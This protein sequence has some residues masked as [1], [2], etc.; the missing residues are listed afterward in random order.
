[1]SRRSVGGAPEPRLAELTDRELALLGLT[2]P[3]WNEIPE[4]RYLDTGRFLVDPSHT[5]RTFGLAATPGDEM[6]GDL[7]R[8]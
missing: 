5:E 3:F 7:L 8:P 2:E 6:V 1:V 4:T